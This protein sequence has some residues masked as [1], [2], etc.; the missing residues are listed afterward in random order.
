MDSLACNYVELADANDGSCVYPETNED[1]NGACLAGSTLLN[2]VYNSDGV[3]TFTVTSTDGS[4]VYAS[5]ALEGEGSIDGCFLTALEDECL[6]LE[7]EGNVPTWSLSAGDIEILTQ[8]DLASG[9]SI[10]NGCDT[11]S[12]NEDDALNTLLVYPNPVSGVLNIEFTSVSNKD[13]TIQFINTLG[14][15]VTSNNYVLT[16]GLLDIKLNTNEYSKGL[17]HVNLISNNKMVNRTIVV[18]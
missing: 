5:D 6:T 4:I 10:G 1:C 15:I 11:S 7:I 8:D 9:G 14:Q 2:L 18:E 13:V 3:S 12:I 16:N 17:Y